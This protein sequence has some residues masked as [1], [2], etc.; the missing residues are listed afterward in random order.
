MVLKDF[1]LDLQPLCK[2]MLIMTAILMGSTVLLGVISS[3]FEKK[4]IKN[5]LAFQIYWRNVFDKLSNARKE[6]KNAKSK[7]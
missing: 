5:L 2:E 1:L 6:R 4:I 7:G 3:I